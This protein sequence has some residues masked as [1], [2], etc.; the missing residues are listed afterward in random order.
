M[1]LPAIGFIGIC[2]LLML[3]VLRLPVA[4]SM[5]IAGV[6]GICY[7]TTPTAGLSLLGREIYGQFSNYSFTCIPMF[8][9]AGCLAFVSGVG[10]GF[11]VVPMFY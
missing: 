4:F 11:L 2:V 10:A 6:A 8:V 5:L 1:S 7:I 3:F 9:F